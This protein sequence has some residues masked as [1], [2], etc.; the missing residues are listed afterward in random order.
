MCAG[1]RERQLYHVCQGN[2]VIIIDII[3]IVTIIIIIMMMILSGD[4]LNNKRFSP[5]SLSAINRVLQVKARGAKGC[6]N[7]PQ[8]V[9]MMMKVVVMMMVMV[10]MMKVMMMKVLMLM[11]MLMFMLMMMLITGTLWQRGG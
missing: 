6:F 8:Q 11:L 2:Q 4:K 3:I 1:W 9:M 10:M 7:E 5:C